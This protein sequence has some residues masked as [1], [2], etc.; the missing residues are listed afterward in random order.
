MG[1]APVPDPAVPLFAGHSFGGLFAL[2]TMATRPDLFNASSPSALRCPGGKEA[3]KRIDRCWR[4]IA[5][6]NRS[7][8][9]TLGDEGAA[10]KAASTR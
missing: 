7:L 6:L 10:M 9:L 5:T 3:V 2:H 4:I 1:R 8:Y